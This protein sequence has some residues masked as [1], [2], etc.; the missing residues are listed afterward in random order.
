MTLRRLAINGRFLTQPITGV[1]R[2]GRELLQALDDLAPPGLAITVFV[3]RR[4]SVE[5][6][7]FRNIEIK[8]AG[9]LRGHA[10]EQFELPFLTKGEV[11]FCP[12]NVAPVLSLLGG[13]KTVVCV[14]DLSYLYFPGAY[15]RSFRLFYNVVVPLV[16]KHA[17]AV[18]TVSQSERSSIVK[19]YPDVSERIFAVQNGGL[20]DALIEKDLPTQPYGRYVLYVGSLSKRKNFPG[21]LRVAIQLAERRSL[22]FVFVGG[23]AKGL[24]ETAYDIPEHLSGY[25]TFKGQVDD[26]ATLIKLY[27]EALCLMFPSFYEASPIPPIE[28]MACGCPVVASDIPSLRERCEAAAVY[29]DPSDDADIGARVQEF[30]DDD[31]HREKIRLA[32]FARSKEFTWK[33]CAERTLEIIADL[34]GDGPR[35]GA[36]R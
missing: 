15:S 14:H 25:I 27:R 36:P 17:K 3:P 12:G 33:A 30:L 31:A 32:G 26:T 13:Q 24:N 9:N 2:Y 34:C 1:Q 16:M 4:P 7:S 19:H 8:Q 35:A 22:G 28:A 11:L 21:M 10:W 6:P 29:C 18:V 20:N 23:A 5:L